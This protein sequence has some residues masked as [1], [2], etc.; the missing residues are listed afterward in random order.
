VLKAGLEN[1]TRAT[2]GRLAD[3]LRELQQSQSGGAIRD[4]ASINTG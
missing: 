3:E 2:F 1:G 4:R